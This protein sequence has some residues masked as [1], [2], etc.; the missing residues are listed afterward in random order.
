MTCKLLATLTLLQLGVGGEVA[1]MGVT[2]RRDERVRACLTRSRVDVAAAATRVARC[3]ILEE[4]EGARA[5]FARRIIGGIVVVTEGT[6]AVML[7]GG[8]RR[9]P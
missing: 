8:A 4:L 3:R 1:R 9:A 2:A 7:W 6:E 5:R